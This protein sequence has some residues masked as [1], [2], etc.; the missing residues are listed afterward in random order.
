MTTIDYKFAYEVPLTHDTDVVVVGGGPGGLGAA[1]MAARMGARTLL[2]ERHGFL[3]GMAV[4]G[5]VH[6]FMSNHVGG[7]CL[8]RPVYLEWI[9]QMKRY[10]ASANPLATLQSE[11]ATA[12]ED[13]Y[14][15]KDIAM[16]AAEDLCLEEGVKLLYHHEL[17]DV[18]VRDGAIDA[19][20]LFSKSGY[21]AVRGRVC[22][23]CTGD[24]DLAARAGCEYEQGGPSGHSQPMT[25]CFKLSHVDRDRIPERKDLFALYDAAKGRGEI[26]CPRENVLYFHWC[27]PDVV[28]FNT[29]RVIQRDATSGEELSD[30]EIE[31]RRQ[32]REF[33][34]FLRKD[35]PGF[36]NA[37]IHS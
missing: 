12:A 17:T 26:D 21:S 35:V 22:I 7:V 5:E 2:V 14:I 27:E 8:D 25:L 37:E 23:D 34:C 36:E 18:L 6:P 4:A 15:S 28:H 1:V 10:Y 3:G 20:I 33:L 32:M 16:L 29:T 19:L 31:G 11:E 24:A 9:R 13:L 30:A